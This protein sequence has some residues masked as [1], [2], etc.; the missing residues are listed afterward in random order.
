MMVL[1]IFLRLSVTNYQR[2]EQMKG[3]RNSLRAGEIGK[4]SV[5]SMT[6]IRHCFKILLKNNL[7]YFYIYYH[8]FSSNPIP[9]I[10]FHNI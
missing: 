3:V 6:T 4:D 8:F 2:R 10:I 1:L 7:F 9:S 5:P